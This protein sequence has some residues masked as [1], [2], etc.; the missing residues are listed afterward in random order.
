MTLHCSSNSSNNSSNSSSTI[1]VRRPITPF[2]MTRNVSMEVRE[3]G[4]TYLRQKNEFDYFKVILQERKYF[5]SFFF[6][7]L[8]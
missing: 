7:I 3:P 1:G 4:L 6:H 2:S 8:T 5:K